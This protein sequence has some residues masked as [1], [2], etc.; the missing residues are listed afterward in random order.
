MFQNLML[1]VLNSVA[2]FLDGLSSEASNKINGLFTGE[3]SR[4]QL[5]EV[6][7]SRSTFFE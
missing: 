1:N 3:R 2:L 5:L 6:S 7:S 4:T